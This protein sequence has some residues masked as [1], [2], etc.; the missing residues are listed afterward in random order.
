MLCLFLKIRAE[1]GSFV[2]V[3][4][5]FTSVLFVLIYK[6]LHCRSELFPCYSAESYYSFVNIID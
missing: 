5:L 6:P 3:P 4:Q 2:S 1:A